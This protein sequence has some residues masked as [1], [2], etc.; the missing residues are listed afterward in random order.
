M[1]SGFNQQYTA[2]NAQSFDGRSA[3]DN[4]LATTNNATLC[5]AST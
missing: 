2:A 1:A 3:A 4:N 5:W